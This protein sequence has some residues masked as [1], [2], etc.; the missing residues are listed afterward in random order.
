M[1]LHGCLTGGMAEVLSFMEY[2]QAAKVME[3]MSALHLA[4]SLNNMSFMLG[5]RIM[6]VHVPITSTTDML[7]CFSGQG[8]CFSIR[9]RNPHPWF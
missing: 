2:M 8:H 7:I 9:Y 6:Q 3:F 1:G 5:G 4:E